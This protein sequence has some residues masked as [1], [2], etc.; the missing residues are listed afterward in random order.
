MAGDKTGIALLGLLAGLLTSSVQAQP[1]V[2]TP[3]QAAAAEQVKVAFA[4]QGDAL[5]P[6]DLLS[7]IHSCTTSTGAVVQD[8]RGEIF[9]VY[10][11][12]IVRP[13]IY[14]L[15]GISALTSAVPRAELVAKGKALEFL[16]GA[17]VAASAVDDMSRTTAEA[18]N[19]VT[20]N[21][22]GEAMQSVSTSTVTTL[23]MI[24]SSQASGLIKGGRVSG[25]K[26]VSLGS[27]L[28][29]C[30]IVRYDIPLNQGSQS[31]SNAAT[32]V[33]PAPTPTV[34]SVPP[35]NPGAPPIPPGSKGDF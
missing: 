33:S 28:G 19:S 11:F 3:E 16:K 22:L 20:K 25:T 24:N 10:G 34:P 12:A 2:V 17:M 14:Q 26:F 27:E 32:P 23:R 8:G 29:F 13:M 30:V 31:N 9:R 5:A 7:Q 21:G 18:A 4:T 1:T 35:S 6:I 15:E